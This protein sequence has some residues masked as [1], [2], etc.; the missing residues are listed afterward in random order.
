MFLVMIYTLIVLIAQNITEA[1]EIKNMKDNCSTKHECSTKRVQN[2]S[3]L[4][5][6]NF[7]NGS[8]NM[9]FYNVICCFLWY[10]P[11]FYPVYEFKFNGFVFLIMY[12]WGHNPRQYRMFVCGY[13][14]IIVLVTLVLSGGAIAMFHRV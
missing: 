7:M 11:Y 10:F 14:I 3:Y 2:L 1:D 13:I 8:Q 4:K 5:Q 9:Q 12:P 6:H